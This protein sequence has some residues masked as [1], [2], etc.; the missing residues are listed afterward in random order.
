MLAQHWLSTCMPS[1]LLHLA[2]AA[3]WNTMLL[4]T[5][6]HVPWRNIALDRDTDPLHKGGRLEGREPAVKISANWLTDL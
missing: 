4:G 2:N 5:D 1:T 3:R 6:T